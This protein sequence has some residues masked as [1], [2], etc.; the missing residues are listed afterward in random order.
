[1]KPRIVLD[2]NIIV[3]GI[4]YGGIPQTIIESVL[5]GSFTLCLSGPLW[6]ELERVLR[7]P[8]FHYSRDVVEFT[9][10]ELKNLAFLVDPKPRLK[11]IKEDPSDN[12]VLEAALAARAEVIVSGDRHLLELKKFRKILILSAREFHDQYLEEA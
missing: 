4:L 5:Q 3:S 11:I 7:Y 10:N 12:R 2:T 9:M 8:K 1:M 6:E